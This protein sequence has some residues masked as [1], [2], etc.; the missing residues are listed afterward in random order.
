MKLRVLPAIALPALVAQPVAA[1]GLFLPGSGAISTSRAGAAVASADDGEALSIN[2]AGLA[3]SSGFTLTISAAITRYYMKFNRAGEYDQPAFAID[4]QGYE[5][6]PFAPVTNEPKPPLGIGTFQPIPVI[7]VVSDLGGRIKGLTLAAGLYAPNG[8][9]FR[10][11]SQGYTSGDNFLDNTACQGTG[12][13]A[14][15]PTRYDVLTSESTALFPSIAAAYRIA[16]SLDIGARFSAGTAKAKTQVM[17]WGTTNNVEE[18]VRNDTFATLDVK[19]G[20]IPTFGIGMTWRP[21]PVL[22]IG[23]VYNAPAVFKTRGSGLSIKGPSVDPAKVVGPIGDN[24]VG[25]RV[26]CEA[27]G[28]FEVGGKVP[29]C[30]NLQLPQNATVAVRY[31]KLDRYGRMRGDLEL[32]VGWENWGKTCDFN[33]EAGI[34][35]NADC[36]SPG[37]FLV[38]LD[39]GLYVNDVFTEALQVNAVNL[40]L[41]DVYT[42]R[43]GGSWIIPVNDGSADPAGW[44]NQIIL[45]G[46]LGHDTRA[47]RDGFL[48]ASFDGAART[49]ATIGAAYRTPKWELNLG[50]GVVF[51]GTN[52][53]ANTGLDG[54]PCN[55]IPA[56]PT[57]CGDGLFTEIEDRRG[58]DPTNP[59][60]APEVQTENPFNQGTITSH[61]VMFMLGYNRFW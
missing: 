13:I 3:K 52:R 37:Q 7:A 19:D 51:E 9:P 17:V 48:R 50:G 40:G 57:G 32:D 27:E 38:N 26:R 15:P 56:D 12:C 2:P 5:G 55:P 53:N 25:D 10:D 18:S 60:L 45:R 30:I 21:S 24:A 42:F 14:P 43:L 8:Y 22:E 31:K 54:G 28:D 49:T 59:L 11:M 20:F 33:S 47:A 41:Q 34:K 23:A 58:P 4:E 29:A 1:G 16:P 46:G 6:Q 61:Y 44:P 35:A 36:T 39:A